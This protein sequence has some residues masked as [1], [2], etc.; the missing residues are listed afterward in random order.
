M[1]YPKQL[2]NYIRIDLYHIDPTHSNKWVIDRAV[3][4]YR[5]RAANAIISS[6][7]YLNQLPV[8]WSTL[9]GWLS[10]EK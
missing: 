10:T 6:V 7:S 1:T 2:E 8:F 9:T 4:K 3:A 5:L